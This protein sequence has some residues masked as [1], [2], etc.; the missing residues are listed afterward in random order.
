MD[1]KSLDTCRMAWAL[2]QAHGQLGD[3]GQ[4][5]EVGRLSEWAGGGCALLAGAGPLVPGVGTRGKAY[6]GDHP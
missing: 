2:T 5:R 4:L 6:R 3:S 1:P